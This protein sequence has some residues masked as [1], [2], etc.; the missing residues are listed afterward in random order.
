M[1][2]EEV[3]SELKGYGNES[4][5]KIFIKHGAQE[6]FFGVKV[7][8]LKKIQKKVKKD[9]ALSLA[10]YDT[11]NSDAMYLAGLIA[12][13]NEVTKD[14]LNK[15]VDGAYW[16]MLSEFTVPWLAADSKHAVDIALEWIESDQERIAAAGWSTLASH[17]G[18]KAD[19]E[20][21]LGLYAKLLD[22]VQLEIHHAQNR[23]RYGMN[24]FVIAIGSWII[25][26]T[27]KAIEVGKEIGKVNV[28][29]G[30]TACKVPLIPEYIEK[31]KSR[32]SLGRKKK[33]ARC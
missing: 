31:V 28:E 11:G 26:L 8:D 7:Q 5:K 15:W 3:M 10:L 22:R 33:M 17:V 21:D 27:E 6:P 14:Q 24:A 32:G 18:I 16:Y 1:T 20:L 9:H 12:D 30:G 13:E 29:M 4:T 23:V 2:V 25:T 19:E